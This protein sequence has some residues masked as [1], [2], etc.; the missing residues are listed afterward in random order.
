[1]TRPALPSGP[2]LAIGPTPTDRADPA[3]LARRVAVV[4]AGL[5]LVWAGAFVVAVGDRIPTTAS[6]VPTAAALLLLAYPLV[7]AVASAV[8]STLRTGRDRRV[9]AVN[10]A[11]SA[12]AAVALA[13]AAFGADAG[14]ALAVFGVW[15]A[16]SGA[17]QLALALGRGRADGRRWPMVVS[18]ALSTVAGLAFVS[19]STQPDANLSGL[20]GY[21]ALGAVLY[22]VWAR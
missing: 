18:G 1:M 11:I 21:A 3:L 19:A 22:L 4:R 6:D 7:D 13:V 12:T 2:T 17:I 10:G 20:A 15:A 14:A 16:V 9:L 5:A 8:G